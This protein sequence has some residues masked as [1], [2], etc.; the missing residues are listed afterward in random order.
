M[1]LIVV[2]HPC[3]NETFC[4]AMDISSER[5]NEL[6]EL[7]DKY[8]GDTESYPEALAGISPHLKNANELAYVSF[9]MG[10]FAESQRTKHELMNK[11]LGE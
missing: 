11:L 7:M 1:S 8:H 10:A 3:P 4:Q 5:E 9:H 2:C 6:D